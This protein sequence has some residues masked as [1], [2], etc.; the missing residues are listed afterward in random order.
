M[1]E[2]ASEIDGAV[3]GEEVDK[4]GQVVDAKPTLGTQAKGPS[5][6][7][8]ASAIKEEPMSES[9]TMLTDGALVM[10]G[11][12]LVDKPSQDGASAMKRAIQMENLTQKEVQRAATKTGAMTTK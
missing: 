5:T 9:Q 3:E 10:N 2:R 12:V 7:K 6:K 8:I 4:K 11:A 1:N